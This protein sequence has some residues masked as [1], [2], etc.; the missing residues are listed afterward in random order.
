VTNWN[1][2]YSDRQVLD[3][4]SREVLSTTLSGIECVCGLSC[5][6]EEVSV[7]SA[8]STRCR[9]LDWKVCVKGTLSCAPNSSLA[10]LGIHETGVLYGGTR[11]YEHA[12]NLGAFWQIFHGMW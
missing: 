5:A 7:L 10:H 2:F 4:M 12:T 8:V 1:G 3:E 6:E 9:Y 11:I